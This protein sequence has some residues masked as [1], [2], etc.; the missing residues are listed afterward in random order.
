MKDSL[1][2]ETEIKFTALCEEVLWMEEKESKGNELGQPNELKIVVEPIFPI[3]GEDVLELLLHNVLIVMQ[4]S[5][6]GPSVKSLI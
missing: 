3:V 6:S 2:E 5:A 1:I 4:P